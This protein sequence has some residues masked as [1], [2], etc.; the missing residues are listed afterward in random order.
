[1]KRLV[2]LRHAKS[3]W[4]DPGADD[5]ARPLNRRGRD[6]APLIGAWIAEQGAKPDHVVC[7]TSLRTRETWALAGLGPEDAPRYDPRLYHA[8]PETLLQVARETPARAET[9]MLI[10]HEP[11]VGLLARRLSGPEPSAARALDQ[12]PTG[13]AAIFE[14]DID[15]WRKIDGGGAR[16]VAFGKPRD[17]SPSDAVG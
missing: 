12:F 17:L 14:F 7:S 13:A 9:A 11:G 3:S 2:L 8:A 1:M 5:H 4:S 16:L 15:D 6:A 10:G